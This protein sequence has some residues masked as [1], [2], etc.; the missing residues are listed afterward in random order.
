MKKVILL[1]GLFAGVSLLFLGS[2]KNPLP[3]KTLLTQSDS[4]TTMATLAP[5]KNKALRK[6]IQS[7]AKQH[8]IKPIDATVDRVWKA[9]PGY[10]GLVVDI[11][12]S[13]QKMLASSDFDTKQL[14]YKETSPQVHLKD[15]PPSPI[16]KGNPEKN[17]VALLINVA[18]GNEF[19]PPILATL[20]KSQV[21]ATFF[22]DGSWVKKNPDLA[23]TIHMEGHEIGN[24]AYSHPNLQHKSQT[25][26]MDELKKTN[27]VIEATVGT[28]PIWFAPPSGSFNQETINIARQLDMLTILW[29]VDSVDWKKPATAEMVKRVVTGV[30]SGSMIL[31]HPTKPTAEGL[32]KMIADIEANGYHLGTVSEIMS[33]NRISERP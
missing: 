15:L 33:E 17:M 5:I 21:K 16:Y 28:K 29:T 8:D 24:H 9:I 18:W 7:L 25:E 26:T 31:M 19:I 32:G 3:E 27:D 13:Y 20:N 30:T 4:I 22:F 6:Q 2:L 10:N 23:K 14:V 11:E 1:L 12:A